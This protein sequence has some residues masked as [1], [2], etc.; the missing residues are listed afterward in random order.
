MDYFSL[1]QFSIEKPEEY[2]NQYAKRL[3]WFSEWNKTIQKDRYIAKWFVNGKTNIA[4]NAIDTHQGTALIWYGENE[5]RIELSFDELK[6]L[7]SSI[8]NLLL[9]KGIYKGNRVAIYSPNSILTIASILGSARIGAIYSLIFAGLGIDAIKSRL[10]DFKPDIIISSTKTFRRGKEIPLLIQGD[11]IFD[12]KNDEEEI[13]KH[14]DSEII[15]PIEVEANEPLKVMYTSGTTGKPKGVILS[16]G[17]WMV[18]DYTVFDLLFDLKPGDKVLTTTDVGWITFSRIMY[19]TLLHGSTFIFLEGAPDYPKDRLIKIIEEEQPKVLFTSPTLIRLLMKYDIR[20]P[21][22]EY[23]ATAGEIFDE[24]S[25]EYALKI[26]DKVTDVYGQSE[27][28]YV[29]GIPY[30][31]EGVEPKIGYA[32]VPLPGAVLDTLD[33][34]GKPIRNNPG[35]LIAKSPFPTQFIGILNNEKKFLEYFDKFGYH[36]T[37]DL[38]I[39]DGTYIKIV[40]RSDDMIKVAGHRITSGEVESVISKID[41]VKDVAVVGIPDEIR[42]EKLAIF[43]VG[44]VNKEEIKKKIVEALGPIYVIH[45]VYLV[46]RLPKSRSGKT[47]RRILRDILLG[48]EFDPSILEDP[49]VVKEIKNAIS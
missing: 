13:R 9:K 5:K 8:S 19:G 43:V 12:R 22:V 28:G 6:R 16:H 36:D 25:W 45:D 48:K 29:V 14:L 44:N 11:I 37:G 18:G 39:F 40:G 27:L 15:P 32:G 23:I 42:G 24:K 7:S 4:Y 1:Y 20:L 17:A 34:N 33:D 10:D 46:E 41:G 3:Y 49:E 47:V 26:A 21:K 2:W 30:A 35:Y 38:A 31:L